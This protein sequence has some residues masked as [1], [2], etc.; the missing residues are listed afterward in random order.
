MVTD[1]KTSNFT[2]SFMFLYIRVGYGKAVPVLGLK[3]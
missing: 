2:L 3:C 1:V